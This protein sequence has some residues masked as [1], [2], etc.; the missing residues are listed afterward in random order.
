MNGLYAITNEQ[1]NKCFKVFSE[2]DCKIIQNMR[3]SIEKNNVLISDNF[4]RFRV[5][6]SS[7]KPLL[8]KFYD[9]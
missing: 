4:E 8:A 9:A 1:I 3:N 2:F 6:D 5:L 7:L